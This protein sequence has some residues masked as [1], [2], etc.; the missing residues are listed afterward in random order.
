MSGRR[1]QSCEG[2][3]ERMR[4][5]SEFQ[6]DLRDRT[7]AFALRIVRRFFI[8]AKPLSASQ[9]SRYIPPP[10]AFSLAR[11]FQALSLRKRV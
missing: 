5:T 3:S 1:R 7:K 11:E 6:R 9:L 4:A 10:A 8:S 2:S